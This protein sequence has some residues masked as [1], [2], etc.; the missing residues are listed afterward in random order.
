MCVSCVFVESTN[1]KKKKEAKQKSEAGL[2]HNWNS[3]FLGHNA[4]AE[5]IADSYNTSKEKVLG[6]RDEGSAAVRL[7]LGET[8]IV[9]QT[10]KYLEQE[11]VILDAFSNNVMFFMYINEWKL[12]LI[13]QK[14]KRSKTV[15]LVKNLPSKTEAKEIRKVFEK[16]GLIGRLILPPSGITGNLYKNNNK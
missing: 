4:V 13:F 15:I 11:G 12:N 3:L 7:A 16:F 5:V 14:C 1:Y 9:A 10:R 8:Q 6:I 2:S